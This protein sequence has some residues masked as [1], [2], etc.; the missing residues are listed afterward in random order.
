M[1]LPSA[2][3][4]DLD[5][6][7]EMDRVTDMAADPVGPLP[8]KRQSVFPIAAKAGNDLFSIQ[9]TLT[10]FRSSSPSSHYVRKSAIV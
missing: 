1:T 4:G 3:I 9:R 2:M 7:A 6:P 5:Q 10:F 8:E